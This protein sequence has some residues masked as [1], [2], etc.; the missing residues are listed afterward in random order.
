MQSRRKESVLPNEKHRQE[1]QG[2]ESY[3]QQSKTGRGGRSAAFPQHDYPTQVERHS[4][5]LDSSADDYATGDDDYSRTDYGPLHGSASDAREDL[6]QENLRF[7]N[8]GYAPVEPSQAAGGFEGSDERIRQ[9]IREGLER[10]PDSDGR[11]V[12][13]EVRRGEVNLRGSVASLARKHEIE[14]VTANIHGVST[15]HSALKVRGK[16]GPSA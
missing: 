2:R 11:G 16:P 1:Y 9:E 12:E 14:R 6:Q 10:A 5:P 8:G 4:Q 7:V 13:V 3:E 15:V